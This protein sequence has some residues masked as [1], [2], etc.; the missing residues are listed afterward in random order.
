MRSKIILGIIITL[1]IA[2]ISLIVFKQEDAADYLRIAI[3][4]LVTTYYCL[5]GN[6]RASFFFYFLLFY[7]FGEIITV[8]YYFIPLT[9][10][11]DNILYFLG[12]SLYIIAYVF[13]IFEILRSMNFS[14]IINRFTIHLI[15]LFALDVYCIV[16]VSDVT[17]KSGVLENIYE[18]I[19]EVVYNMTVMILLTTALIN[20]LYRDSKKAMNLLI[21]AL[22]IVF[23]EVIQVAYFYV[24]EIPMLSIVYSMLLVMA[25]L[26]FY[27]QNSMTYQDNEMLKKQKINELKT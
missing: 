8:L 15:I 26:F 16:L 22:C 12:N 25:F 24:S 3:L 1:A 5:S 17:I 10:F 13:L 21:G 18:N 19:L 6:N 4:P 27:I 14:V 11:I 7:S 20:Y 9:L 23:S 2:F